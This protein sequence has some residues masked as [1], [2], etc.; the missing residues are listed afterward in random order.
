[1]A[2]G[3]WYYARGGQQF[4]PVPAEEVKGK[5]AS[6][7][8][9]PQDLVWRDGMANWQP[10]ATVPELAVQPPAY[11]QGAGQGA[12]EVSGGAGAGFSPPAGGEYGAPS[13]YGGA[14]GYGA[15]QGYSGQPG[16]GGPPIGQ[17][18]NYG[19]YYRTS[20]FQSPEGPPPPNHLVGAILATIFCCVPLGIV[21]IV[22][23]AQVN[24]KHAAGDHAGAIMAADK[25]NAWMWW[26]FGSGLVISVLYMM[27]MIMANVS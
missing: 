24:T 13:P 26:S 16:Y 11:S 7:E 5:L 9:S 20:A 12:Y 22:Y 1:M 17:P 14:P 2:E 15:P 19:G 18:L 23:A 8:L 25:A 27:L 21:A 10:A 3:T 6:G 4:G